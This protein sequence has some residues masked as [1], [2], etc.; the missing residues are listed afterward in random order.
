ML[1]MLVTTVVAALALTGCAR[2]QDSGGADG[3]TVVTSFYPLQFVTE[4]I[5]GPR[6]DV[7]SLTPPGAEPHDLE[8]TP[9]DVATI[10]DS[11]LVVLVRGFQPAVDTAVEQQAPERELDVSQAARLEVLG[12]PADSGPAPAGEGEDH[13]D[14]VQGLDPHFW[15]D[16]LR[17]ADVAD[18]VA[19]RLSEIDPEGATAYA[20]NL[21]SLRADLESLDAD[22]ASGLSTCEHDELVVS[23]E[24]FGYLANR[25]GLLQV[26]ISGLSPES[27]PSALTLAEVT[28][29]V[30]THDVTTIFTEVLVDP[31]VAETVAKETGATVAVLDPV[32]GITSDSA[33]QDYLAVMRAN[34]AALRTGLECA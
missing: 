15:L 29:F 25:F 23:H 26:G 34:L 14:P 11:D 8:L 33:G 31:A 19:E 24:A 20:A 6:V 32:E 28:D 30:T 18:A 27:E 12:G 1:R 10:V 7:V 4:R 13:G 22:M 3:P 16:P 5:A 17:L 2:G 21:A 9:R